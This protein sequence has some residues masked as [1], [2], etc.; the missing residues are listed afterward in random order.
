MTTLLPLKKMTTVQKLRAMEEL[1]VD[2]SQVEDG[3]EIPEWQLQAVR[4]TA[5]RVRAG[6]EKLIP[7]EE[8]KK[9]LRRRAK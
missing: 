3:N 9:S 1:W 4:E 7:W 2:L 5:R 8:A 6:T